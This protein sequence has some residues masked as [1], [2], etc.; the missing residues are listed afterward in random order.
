MKKCMPLANLAL[1]TSTSLI[2][3]SVTLAG[4]AA[5][6]HVDQ[7]DTV[8]VEPRVALFRRASPLHT[9]HKDFK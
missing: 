3:A 5:A 4:T 6:P 9:P 1:G 7:A 8:R 2:F